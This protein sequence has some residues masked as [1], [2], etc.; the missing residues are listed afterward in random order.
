[1]NTHI[2]FTLLLVLVGIVSR[3]VPAQAQQPYAREVVKARGLFE[4]IR[5]GKY[6]EFFA[7]FNAR[8]FRLRGD[9]PRMLDIWQEAVPH[10][11]F[12]LGFFDDIVTDPE[13]MDIE[14]PP[15][16]ELT[17]LVKRGHAAL[18]YMIQGQGIVA[19]ES[20]GPGT[21]AL[22]DDGDQI[23]VRTEGSPARFLLIS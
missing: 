11:R 15:E 5:T 19:G 3:A 2:R 20:V 9:Y 17:K 21:A 13:Y 14:I 23:A 7:V 6:E 1:M 16:T 10:E 8:P 12:F 4:L 18:A 22:F